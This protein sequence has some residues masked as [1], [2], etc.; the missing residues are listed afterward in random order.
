MDKFNK[1]NFIKNSIKHKKHINEIFQYD[2]V[3][4]ILFVKDKQ[5]NNIEKEKSIVK[6]D[7]KLFLRL[8]KENIDY[9][10]D[11]E[12][13][14]NEE[15][16]I[17]Q[18]KEDELND[19][20]RKLKNEITETEKKNKELKQLELYHKN[21]CLKDLENLKIK[22][23]LLKKEKLFELAYKKKLIKESKKELNK[24][25]DRRTHLKSINNS[26]LIKSHSVINLIKTN[27]T[28]ANSPLTTKSKNTIQS[29]YKKLLNDNLQNENYNQ[30]KIIPILFKPEERE[31]LENFIPND[32]LEKYE[33]KFNV[34][35][36]E[37]NDLE[38]NIN[39]SELGKRKENYKKNLKENE[40]RN[41]KILQEFNIRQN[42]IKSYNQ[43]IK[44]LKK[45][46]CEIEKN[47]IEKKEEMKF[48]DIEQK[49]KKQEIKDQKDLHKYFKRINSE[50]K[51]KKRIIEMSGNM[52]FNILSNTSILKNK[53]KIL[54][55]IK[56]NQSSPELIIKSKK[57]K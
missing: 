47:I 5:L 3:D 28:R 27:S 56:K 46:I 29:F 17:I 33:N 18:S 52:S 38:N 34:L 36:K 16:I 51:K 20:L 31:V 13:I 30:R 57:N 43:T 40:V 2:S 41:A 15:G 22:R 8:K 12:E 39:N 37:K 26:T 7:I 25:N 54:K 23:E 19:Y 9:K 14:I 55:N 44:Y 32:V 4:E 42:Q 45:K 10:N 1:K 35:S 49:R 21:N 50:N 48:K 53:K 11:D 6:K 24:L